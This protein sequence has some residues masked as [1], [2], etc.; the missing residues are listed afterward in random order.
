MVEKVARDLPANHSE[1]VQNPQSK[2]QFTFDT[3]PLY[4][5]RYVTLRYVLRL[6][7]QRNM[8][9]SVNTVESR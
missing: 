9:W 5:L 3:Q 1:A 8:T 7:F 2:A 4:A 6:A